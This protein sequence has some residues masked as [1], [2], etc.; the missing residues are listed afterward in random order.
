MMPKG[1]INA[2]QPLQS[3]NHQTD[4]QIL[5]TTKTTMHQQERVNN[6]PALHKTLTKNT[7]RPTG[8]KSTPPLLRNNYGLRTDATRATE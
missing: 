2:W 3:V 8:Y 5:T 7:H 4:M 1:C 6:P